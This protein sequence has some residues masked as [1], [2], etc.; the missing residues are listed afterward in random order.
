MWL[1]GSVENDSKSFKAMQPPPP[2]HP[3]AASDAVWQ[4]VHT[5]AIRVFTRSGRLD[6]NSCSLEK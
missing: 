5:L 4:C 1:P 2:P 3:L 6:P